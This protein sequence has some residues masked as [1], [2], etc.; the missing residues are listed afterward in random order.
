MN[1][2]AWRGLDLSYRQGFLRV[3]RQD[4][5]KLAL[6]CHEALLENAL[7]P[8]SSFSLSFFM[9]EQISCI[10]SGN[11]KPACMGVSRTS[12]LDVM[13]CFAAFCVV[14]IHFGSGW[15]SPITRCA[16]PI[17]FV[18]TGY[19]YPMMVEKGNLWRHIRKLLVMVLCSS[20]LYGVVEVQHMIRHDTFQ[21]WIS[22]TFKLRPIL[23]MIAYDYDL[24]AMH[25]WY[26]Y[27]VLYDLVIFYFADKWK[28][29]KY[30]Q[31]A[32]LLLLFLFFIGNFAPWYMKLRN[33]LFM[34]LP[35]MMIGRLVGEKK[36]FVF[37]F[38][39]R[40]QYLLLYTSIFLFLIVIEMAV[41]NSLYGG[42]GIREMFIFT[43]PFIL[44]WFYWALRNPTFGEE[45]VFATIG[46]KYSAYIYIF[47]ILA[48]RLLSHIVEWDTPLLSRVIYP[49]LIFGIS[50][51]MAWL[52]AKMMQWC[53]ARF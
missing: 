29:I 20:A 48:A 46:R 21:E 47:H 17:F 52:F 10:V 38:L 32:A 9:V 37:S 22:N 50:L 4:K 25:L 27:A 16:V 33:F 51:C 6:F 1:A 18:I 11:V 3:S 45:S 30:L 39:A 31:Y 8:S 43:L 42:L 19:Y 44:P 53:K 49:F 2:C 24:F 36:D 13:K 41:Y 40:K 14:W 15:L 26:F 7:F 34:G 35:C 5:R 23:R 12:S 28:L